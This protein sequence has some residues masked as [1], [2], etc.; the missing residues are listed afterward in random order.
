MNCLTVAE[1][2]WPAWIVNTTDATT[3]VRWGL[4]VGN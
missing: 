1:I 2:R 4:A 3:P